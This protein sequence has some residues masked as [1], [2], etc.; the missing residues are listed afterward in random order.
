[1]SWGDLGGYIFASVV[2]SGGMLSTGVIFYGLR[3]ARHA[4]ASEYLS[5]HPL[6]SFLFGFLFFIIPFLCIASMIKSGEKDGWVI[7]LA[8]TMAIYGLGMSVAGRNLAEKMMPD[9]SAMRQVCVGSI[10]LLSSLI[11]PF[12]GFFVVGIAVSMGFGAWIR[13]RALKPVSHDAVDS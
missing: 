3:G 6:K 13:A 5:T 8:I 7:V 9:A 1:M 4:K 10:V 11:W 2:V 12:S